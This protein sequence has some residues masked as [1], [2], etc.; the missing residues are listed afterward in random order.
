MARS[1]RDAKRPV[2]EQLAVALRSM[3]WRGQ[4]FR[5]QRTA[6]AVRGEM[7]LPD[8]ISALWFVATYK[9]GLPPGQ[10]AL[11]PSA[12]LRGGPI[13]RAMRA[14][15]ALADDSSWLVALQL[16][17]T[18]P[19]QDCIPA[20]EQGVQV[21]S[22]FLTTTAPNVL[23]MFLDDWPGALA[24]LQQHPQQVR[25]PSAATLALQHLLQD[26]SPQGEKLAGQAIR[27]LIG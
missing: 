27:D 25:Y 19:Y 10:F 18:D 14:G 4:M 2:L 1:I 11:A 9:V 24:F 22:T 17:V 20:D 6:D 23:A 21:C 26:P 3:Q 12:F 8:E 15:G 7:A 13:W 16:T 5:V